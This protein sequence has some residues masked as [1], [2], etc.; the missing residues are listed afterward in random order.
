MKLILFYL[1]LCFS[2]SCSYGQ[3]KHKDVPIGI[4]FL[5]T[6]KSYPIPFYKNEKDSIPFDILKFNVK[7]NGT[8]K[9]ITKLELK[10]YMISEGDTF[11]E[12]KRNIDNGLVHFGPELKFR[13]IDSTKTHFKVVTNESY[14]EE[15]YIK[16]EP[17]KT[18]YATLSEVFKNSCANCP[19]SNQNNDWNVFETWERYL[20][21]VEYISKRELKIY[22]KP[23]GK[24]IFEVNNNDFLPFYVEETKGD[25]IKLKKD[26][27]RQYNFDDS[28]NYNG[29]TQWK[30]GNKIL[31]EITEET[32]F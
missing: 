14:N 16:I 9:F 13:V 1:S 28:K 12:G 8:I 6:N 23:N 19:N 25:W 5:E 15:Y 30:N 18:Y 31:I 22:D 4:G 11:K 20:K 27:G 17:Q 2:I 10:P 3:E 29:W 24:I 7:K 32:Y 26:F 21:R